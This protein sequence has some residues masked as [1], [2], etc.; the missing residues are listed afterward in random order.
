[1]VA[2]CP[3]IVGNR[4]DVSSSFPEQQP[5]WSSVAGWR[6]VPAG[7]ALLVSGHGETGH[8]LAD[9]DSPWNIHICAGCQAAQMWGIEGLT[10]LLDTVLEPTA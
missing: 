4:A 7:A 6:A 2:V 8:S 5:I 1:M 3:V 9:L 10:L